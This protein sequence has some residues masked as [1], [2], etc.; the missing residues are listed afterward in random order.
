M[1]DN[2][3]NAHPNRDEREARG[4]TPLTTRAGLLVPVIAFRFRRIIHDTH[5]PQKPDGVQSL[6]L[7]RKIFPG[8]RAGEDFALQPSE[9]LSCLE[10]ENGDLRPAIEADIRCRHA[11]TPVCVLVHIHHLIQPG[12]IFMP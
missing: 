9:L 10:R 11:Y 4:S 7:W 6:R 5:F 3:K 12:W 1:T 8:G 2:N